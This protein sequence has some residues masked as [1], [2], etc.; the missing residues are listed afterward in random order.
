MSK[1]VLDAS[2]VLAFVKSEKGAEKVGP[3]MNGGM[4]SA[5]NYSEVLK[6]SVE[7]GGSVEVTAKLLNHAQVVVIPFDSSEAKQ[8]AAMWRSV[9]ASGLSFAD[10]ACLALGVAENAVVLTAN[11]RMSET[12]LAV[13]VRMIR[14][15]S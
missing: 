11:R 4:M 8:A 1:F 10:R 3:H 5:V 7:H 15:R 9:K 2:A 12:D 14:E 6:K 13:K